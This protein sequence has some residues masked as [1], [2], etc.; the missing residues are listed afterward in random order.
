MTIGKLYILKVYE[1][2]ALES[3]IEERYK[4][5]EGGLAFEINFILR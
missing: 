1:L 4:S 2:I 5:Q 3:A